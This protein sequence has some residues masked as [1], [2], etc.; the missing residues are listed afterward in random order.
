MTSYAAHP[1]I[2]ANHH[3]KPKHIAIIMDGNGRWAKLRHLSRTKGHRK[4]VEVVREIIAHCIEKKIEV[5]TLFAFGIENWKRPAQEVRTLFRLFYLLLRREINK[6]HQDNI[7]LR[8]VGDRTPF[9]SILN[10]AITEAQ[11]LTQHNTGLILNI[12]VNYSGRWDLLN[13]IRNIA[14]NVTQ[15]HQLEAE[16]TKGLAL[17]GLPE[18]DLFIRT[19][20][21]KRISNFMLWELAYTE[22]YFS[23]ILWPD[24]NRIELQKALDDFATRERRFGLTGDQLG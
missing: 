21:V 2:K 3:N 7:K 23:D 14:S 1:G 22:L 19:G 9:N 5:L 13:A 17:H 11:N 12:A 16:F 6:I 10:K 20:G 15:E 8:I 24:F 18:P 4:G